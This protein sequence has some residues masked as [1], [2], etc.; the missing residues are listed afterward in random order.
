MSATMEQLKE[1]ARLACAS[2][3][4]AYSATLRGDVPVGSRKNFDAVEGKPV[5]ECMMWRM[6]QN[7]ILDCIGVLDRTLREPICSEEHWRDPVNGHGA[8]PEEPVPTEQVWYIRTL[9]GR[10][11]RW[12]NAL[13]VRVPDGPD[14]RVMNPITTV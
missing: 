7:N 6:G 2:A 13:F 4:A 3:Y 1:A 12:T 9:D 5:F 10:E 11:V 14:F 8:Y